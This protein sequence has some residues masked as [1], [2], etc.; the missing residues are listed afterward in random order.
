[1]STGPSRTLTMQVS[2]ELYDRLE[3]LAEARNGPVSNTAH[4]A[5]SEGIKAIYERWPNLKEAQ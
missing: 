4:L 2:L 3:K 1:M 5:L